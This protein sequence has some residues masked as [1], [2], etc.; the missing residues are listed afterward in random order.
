MYRRPKRYCHAR[1]IHEERSPWRVV[2]RI[3]GKLRWESHLVPYVQYATVLRHLQ[4]M[5]FHGVL[6]PARE[7]GF[8]NVV[9]R[10]IIPYEIE[11][12]QG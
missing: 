8:L 5:D 12:E 9:T 2:S 10:E 7:Y 4:E 11:Y 6:N 3:I 1:A